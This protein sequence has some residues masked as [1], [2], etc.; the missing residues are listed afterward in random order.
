MLKELMNSPVAWLVLALVTVCSL[1]LTIITCFKGRRN[2]TI[3]WYVKANKII[4][5]GKT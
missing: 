4:K 2:K 1:I 5:G 3:S